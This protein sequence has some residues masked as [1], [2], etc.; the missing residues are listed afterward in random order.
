MVYFYL[1]VT[2]NGKE[3]YHRTC[4]GISNYNW[5]VNECQK[6]EENGIKLHSC[7]CNE[8]ACNGAGKGAMVY[9]VTLITMAMVAANV[10]R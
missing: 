9:I 5:E 8:D 1:A 4:G 2:G 7:I 6:S 3:T 10:A